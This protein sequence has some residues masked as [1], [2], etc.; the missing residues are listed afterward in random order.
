MEDNPKI[1]GVRIDSTKQFNGEEKIKE[2]LNSSGQKTIFTPNP[3]M[4]VDAQKDDKFKQILNSSSLNICDGKGI[5]MFSRGRL[6]RI[7]GVDFL[8]EIAKIAE[9][10]GKSIYLLGSGDDDVLQK[11]VLELKKSFPNLKIVGVNIGPKIKRL[12]DY[13]I[14]IDSEIND[15]I[16]DD[17][18]LTAPD[19][20]F[21]AF[22]HIKQEK[23][24]NQFLTDL[25][26]VKIAMGVGGSFDF[27]SGKIKRAPNWVRRFG[28][29]WL[30]RLAKQPRRILRI[31]KAI[32]LFTFLVLKNDICKK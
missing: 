28:I 11:T 31:F 10:L 5:E 9:D 20:L 26:S 14:E 22:G 17:I 23:W 6:K 13:K 19:I 3:E 12:K 2:F 30:W 7:T 16:L 21:V 15:K 8:L 18:I 1:M 24:I 25:P 27:I 4:I 29:E 32:F